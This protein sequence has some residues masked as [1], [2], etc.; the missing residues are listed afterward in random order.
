MRSSCRP[1]APGTANPSHSARTGAEASVADSKRPAYT[2]GA[3]RRS[4]SASDVRPVRRRLAATLLVAAVLGAGGPDVTATP[5]DAAE[6]T[7]LDVF[8]RFYRDRDPA[9]RRKAVAQLSGCRGDDVV[10]AVLRALADD[11]P[12]VRDRASEVLL[13]RRDRPDEIAAL[14]RTGLGKQ[15]PE[16]RF[17]AARALALAGPPAATALRGALGDRDAA[18]QRV[19]A[20]GL[21][22][23]GDRA[24][25]P[26]LHEVLLSRDASV[27]AVACES[28]GDL[29]GE[30]A[31]GTATAV[32][33]G[34]SAP[35]PRIAA[36]EILA[37][38]PTAD[39][40]PQVARALESAS[41]SLR[42]AASKALREFGGDAAVARAAASA[43]VAALRRESRR[44]VQV[45]MGESLWTLTGIDFGPDPP[46]W[47]AW[48]AKEGE[49][50]TPPGRRPTR[51]G[52]KGQG[53]TRG[54]LLDL[55][56]ESEHVSFVLDLSS[57]MGEPVKF[58]SPTTKRAE[59]LSAFE[60]VVGRLPKPAWINL[61][62]F[63]TAPQPY[64]PKLFEAT[65]P[66][67]AAVVKHLD[68]IPADGRTN[69]FDSLELALSDPEVD[70]TV[71]VTDGAP[72][73]GKRTTRSGILEGLRELNRWRFVR[74]HTVEVGAANT[75]ARWRGFL[76]EIAE[77][78]GG[79]HL[80]R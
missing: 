37:R 25:A 44:R 57:S 16:V 78:T 18:V 5:T 30:G 10:E 46:R 66:A 55:P 21:A 70:T 42:V 28:I 14:V 43:L 60:A 20:R 7:P 6:P 68:R 27:R 8:H 39:G 56:I 80:Q 51:G 23:C 40:A 62:P 15:P 77:A 72:S 63:S 65:P 1:P 45:E 53:A 31:V 74:V 24:A 69:V 13:E 32:L 22:A 50:F 29:L 76:R 71:L 61:I 19:A 33:L 38:H 11:D 35:E 17:L 26:A 2:A 48:H 12:S 41:W 58:G 64:K 59:L 4:E 36:V 3:R 67:R 34:D 75:G 73:V 79:N 49:T 54:H 52:V 9:L 47:T